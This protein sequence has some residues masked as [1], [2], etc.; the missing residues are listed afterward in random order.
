VRA[1]L[2][3]AILFAHVTEDWIAG[4]VLSRRAPEFGEGEEV[5]YLIIGNVTAH[6][7]QVTGLVR[8][9]VGHEM[10][11]GKQSQSPNRNRVRHRVK[12]YSN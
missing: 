2:R 11:L 7:Q 9:H 4:L 6:S 1:S 8:Q 5:A 3:F 12:E 10:V